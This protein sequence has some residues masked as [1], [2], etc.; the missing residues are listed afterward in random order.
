MIPDHVHLLVS[1]PPKLNV[2][3]FMEYLK[4]KS[5]L[6]MLDRYANLKYKFGSRHF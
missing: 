1:I 3:Q 2:S 4:E 5:A 6:M